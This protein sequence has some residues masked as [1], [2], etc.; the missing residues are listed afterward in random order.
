MLSCILFT[1]AAFATGVV[2]TLHLDIVNGSPL[3]H[4]APS[5]IASTRVKKLD[6]TFCTGILIAPR[7]V[8]TTASCSKH[9]KW[10]TLNSIH[11]VGDDGEH[12]PVVEYVVHPKFDED[13]LSFG[14]GVVVLDYDSKNTPAILSFDLFPPPTDVAVRGFGRLKYKGTLTD[15]LREAN[16]TITSNSVCN[17]AYQLGGFFKDDTICIVGLSPCH[18]DEGGPSSLIKK[19]DMKWSSPL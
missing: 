8:L 10:V 7:Y 3:E 1:V 9:A 4:A 17:N 15:I 2:A 16:G 6:Y 14:L 13:S 18:W 5:Y 19:E 11:R 12:I